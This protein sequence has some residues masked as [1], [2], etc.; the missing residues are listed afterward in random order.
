VAPPGAAGVLNFSM[1]WRNSFDA[2]PSL[3]V[4]TLVVHGDE[5][6]LIPWQN[7]A[8]LAERMPRARWVLIH[9]V[10]H[11]MPSERPVELA[12]LIDEFLN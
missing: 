4:D 2:L 3:D 11:V 7:G 12:E 5:D 6:V 1:P 8:M 10:G 9:G